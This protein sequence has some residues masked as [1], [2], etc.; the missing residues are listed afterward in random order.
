MP[1]DERIAYGAI[2]SWWDSIDKVGSTSSLTPGV[3]SDDV[4]AIPCCP[5]CKGV[6]FEIPT[7]AEW[8]K[9]VD[10]Y[11]KTPGNENYRAFIEWARGKCFKGGYPEA[12]E[13]FKKEFN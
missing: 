7:E 13:A 8:F 10:A 9:S 12:K 11:A 1:K 4:I 2:C 5:H 6:L 3:I